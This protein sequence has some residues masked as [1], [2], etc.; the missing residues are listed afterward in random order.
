[1]VVSCDVLAHWLCA[2]VEA[3][4]L[5]VPADIAVVGFDWLARWDDPSM[6][7]ITTA[8]QDFEGFGYHAAEFLLDR[9][10]DEFE[11]DARQ[12]LLPAPLVFRYSTLG[13]S[14]TN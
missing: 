2:A 5:S 1:I 11:L 13:D 4:G 9:A 7:L 6:D 3:E 12:I 10:N 8:S 14:A